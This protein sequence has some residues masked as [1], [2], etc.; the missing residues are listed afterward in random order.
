MTLEQR[1]HL[2]DVQPI[3]S[4]HFKFTR[5][6]AGHYTDM[7]HRV[8]VEIEKV[9]WMGE[10]SEIAWICI[11]NG[12]THDNENSADLLG[13]YFPTKRDAIEWAVK[14]LNYKRRK[15]II[16]EYQNL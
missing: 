3:Q 13:D 8:K 11:L 2:H 6:S 9:D 10:S 14:R 7:M 4:K 1:L 16:T 5:N 15:A 12:E